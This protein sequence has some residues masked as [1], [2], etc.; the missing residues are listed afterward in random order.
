MVQPALIWNALT[1]SV[2]TGN[3]LLLAAAVV[4]AAYLIGS[5]PTAYLVVRWR[6]GQD[7]RRL[8]DG[9]V[10]AENAGRI[11][12]L[13]TGVLV[14]VIDIAKGLAVVLLA[15]GLA[16]G[17]P[18]E[19]PASPI[20]AILTPEDYR[21]SL[22]MLA[23]TAAVIGHSWPLYL[24]GPGGRGAA[25]ALGALLGLIPHA[26]G[27]VLLPGLA[28][29][30]LTRSTTWGLATFFIGGVALAGVFGYYRLFDYSWLP[31]AYA[32]A[33]PALVGL[34]HYRSVCRAGPV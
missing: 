31:A 1:G 21:Q 34:I 13:K 11:L 29:T 19:P 12:G 28:V 15:R 4:A 2:L 8:G 17:G 16:M 25:T 32:G 30:F 10:G 3:A 20:L 27:P 18:T 24:R 33:L 9:N 23:G 5:T 26:A 6:R 7:I 22:A 14:A